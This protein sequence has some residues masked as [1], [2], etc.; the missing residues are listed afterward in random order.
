M[1]RIEGDTYPPEEAQ[2]PQHVYEPDIYA[3][4]SVCTCGRGVLDP[5]HTTVVRLI[6]GTATP[7][8]RGNQ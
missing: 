5:I 7:N 4:R 2:R 6:Q 8:K 1:R 3:S